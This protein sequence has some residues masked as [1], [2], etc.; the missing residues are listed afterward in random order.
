MDTEYSIANLNFLSLSAF[1]GLG[2][3]P[4]L[5]SREV[6]F[7]SFSFVDFCRGTSTARTR[8]VGSCGG[9]QLLSTTVKASYI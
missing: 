9:L 7:V 4:T 5:F 8:R 6:L 1:T 3:L 2:G